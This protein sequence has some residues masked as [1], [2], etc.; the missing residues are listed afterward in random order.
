MQATSK[1]GLV[2]PQA[3]QPYRQ[4]FL[5]Q[6]KTTKPGAGLGKTSGWVHRA[7]LQRGWQ[8][9]LVVLTEAAMQDV[10][11]AALAESAPRALVEGG[12]VSIDPQR[13]AAL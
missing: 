2:E 4:L 11:L 5:L 10:A 9:A 3:A 8:P 12:E 13:L 6:R 7:A 1:G